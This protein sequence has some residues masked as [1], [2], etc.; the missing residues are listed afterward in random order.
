MKN[1]ALLYGGYSS[2]FEISKLSAKNIL[3]NLP[4]EYNSFLVEVTREGWKAEIEGEHFPI[5]WNDLSFQTKEGQKFIDVALVF[6]H[7]EPGENGKIQ[8][9]LDMKEIPTINSSTLASELSFDKWYCN[10]FLKQCGI[11]VAKSIRLIKGQEYDA[12]EVVMQLGLPLFVKPTDSGS[13]F[14]VSKVKSSDELPKAIDFAFAE[15]KTVIMESFLDGRELCCGVYRSKSGVKALPITEII[16][17]GEFF[18]YEAKY[19]GQ[20]QEITPADLPEDIKLKIQA[21][22]VKIYELLQLKSIARVDFMLVK[23]EPMVIEVNAVPGFS[24]ASLVP[25]M[26]Q[27]EGIDLKSFWKEVIEVCLTQS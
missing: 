15:G 6:I 25:Q 21:E 22:T 8:S 12:N 27:E 3:P 20:S 4:E 11:P 26:L 24:E 10:T 14:G 1:L 2:E 7:G 18:D 17:N 13:S 5:D 16:A 23:G 9:F 19:K